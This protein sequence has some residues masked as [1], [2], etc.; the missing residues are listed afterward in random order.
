MMG[1]IWSLDLRATHR[2]Y[3]QI[4]EG[5][6]ALCVYVTSRRMRHLA[7]SIGFSAMRNRRQVLANMKRLP[8]PRRYSNN[9]NNT[10]SLSTLR[11][12]ALQASVSAY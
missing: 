2:M 1:R 10:S 11:P 12:F 6:R 9:V 5:G 4:V 8:V 7:N 3:G